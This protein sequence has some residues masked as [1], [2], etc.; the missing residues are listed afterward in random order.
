MGIAI[1]EELYE[2]IVTDFVS[3]GLIDSFFPS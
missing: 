3:Q 1:G 2:V